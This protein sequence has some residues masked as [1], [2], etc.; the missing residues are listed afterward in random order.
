MSNMT[1]QH[2]Q[3]YFD[4][5]VQQPLRHDPDTLLEAA[6]ETGA[7]FELDPYDVLRFMVENKPL[8]GTH[9]YGFQTAYGRA[10]ADQFTFIYNTTLNA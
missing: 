10:I 7:M 6:H 8:N 9:S 4:N 5:V 2:V 1:I 3:E